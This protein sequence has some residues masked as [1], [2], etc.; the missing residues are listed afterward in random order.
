MPELSWPLEDHLALRDQLLTAYS[1]GRGY[2]DVQHLAEV[3]ERIEELG[4][5]SNREVV[6]AAWYH[7]AI[8]E[9]GPDD[10]ERSAQ[11]A[12]RELLG[13][14]VDVAEVARLV[15]LTT[16]HDPASDDHLGQVLCD[17]DL[18]IL[19]ADPARYQEYSAGVRRD[20]DF[21]PDADFRA[22]RR[23][24]LE[25]LLARDALFRT[26]HARLEWDRRARENLTTEIAALA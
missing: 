1:T 2:H 16:T 17:A 9:G 4:E 7:D 24:V 10:E 21:V 26:H 11:L 8:Y 25:D 3:L 5:G 19:A 12:E 6:L 15:R 18:A 14:G 22:G 23:A 13:T 20:Y